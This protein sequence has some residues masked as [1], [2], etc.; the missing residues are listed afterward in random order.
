MATT[1]Q[2]RWRNHPSVTHA[3][4]APTPLTEAQKQRRWAELRRQATGIDFWCHGGPWHRRRISGS[5]LGSHDSIWLRQRHGR[6]PLP[7]EPCYDI[8]DG[9]YGS[10][11]AEGRNLIWGGWTTSPPV[12]H[13]HRDEHWCQCRCVDH[14]RNGHQLLAHLKIP[15]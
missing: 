8:P 6:W 9:R 5:L 14:T 11:T 1:R 3:H 10:Y 2:Q 7:G 13:R 4:K 15:G 12:S